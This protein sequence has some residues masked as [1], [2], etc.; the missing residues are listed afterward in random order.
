MRYLLGKLDQV[1]AM[2]RQILEG[3]SRIIRLLNKESQS[4][5][6]ITDSVAALRDT[7][8]AVE[9]KDAAILAYVQGVPALITAAVEAANGDATA[10]VA[11]I[12]AL[13]AELA[14]TPDAIVAAINANTP[15][16]PL[17][18]PVEAPPATT[19]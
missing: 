1:L 10:A 14:T 19:P 8:T 11:N 6:Q 15:A 18:P 7:V 9:T 4:M 16:A 12:N 2:G 13:A 17:A 3:Q 5:S